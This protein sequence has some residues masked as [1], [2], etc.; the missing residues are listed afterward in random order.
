[1]HAA[2]LGLMPQCLTLQQRERGIEQLHLDALEGGLGGLNVEQVQD[3]GLVGAEHAATC[4]LQEGQISGYRMS[5]MSMQPAGGRGLRAC[6]W[7]C[8][9]HW[10][11]SVANLARSSGN[12]DVFRHI[13]DGD[14]ME[15][16]NL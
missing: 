6:C 8:G 2:I 5:G 16:T 9:Y 3:D 12:E 15:G 1:M 10:A 14:Q 13:R 4:D 7:S 11:E